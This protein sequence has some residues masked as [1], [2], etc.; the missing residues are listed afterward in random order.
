M[1]DPFTIITFLSSYATG[2]KIGGLFSD[3]SYGKNIQHLQNGTEFLSEGIEK[4]DTKILQKAIYEFDFIN[5]N[6]DRLFAVSFSYLYRAVC[7]TYLLDFSLAYYYLDKLEAIDYDFMTRKKDSIEETKNDG[8]SF[9]NE[10]EK[11]ERAYNEYLKSL[12]NQG[13]DEGNSRPNVLWKKSFVI[14]SCIV[15]IGVLAMLFFVFI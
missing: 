8:R 13:G 5:E 7:Y 10:V 1:V 14:L 9:R 12:N 2:W 3:L 15:I 4:Q 11:L 6:D